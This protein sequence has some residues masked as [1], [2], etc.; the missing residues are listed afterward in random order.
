MYAS[1]ENYNKEDPS[2]TEQIERVS[3]DLED[4]SSFDSALQNSEVVIVDA[5]AS[6]CNPCKKIA[7][8]FEELGHL[9]LSFVKSGR[10]LL[11]KDNIENE[12]S[13]HKNDVHVVPTF[14]VYIRGEITKVYTGVEFKE[15]ESF[16]Y[17]YF[18]SV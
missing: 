13:V 3:F 12:D 9:F 5:W 17:N 4:S 15:L 6:W 11:L 1:Y 18:S 14:F 10:L 2:S 16:I 7:P 8:K